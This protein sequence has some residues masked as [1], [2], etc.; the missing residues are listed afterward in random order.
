MCFSE[1]L[2]LWLAARTEIDCYSRWLRFRQKDKG[3]K[4]NASLIYR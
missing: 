4:K 3:M 2:S 1:A